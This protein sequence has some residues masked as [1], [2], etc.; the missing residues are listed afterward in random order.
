MPSG[1]RPVSE[2]SPTLNLTD[3]DRAIQELREAT[4]SGK[5]EDVARAAMTNIW[6]LYNAH[7][8][9]L[10]ASVEALPWLTLKQYPVLRIL[11]RMTPVLA[12]STAPFKPL[13]YPADARNMSQDELDIL[14]LVQMVAFRL[15]GD[16]AA[17]MIHARRLQERILNDRSSS[18]E[19]IDGPLWFYHQQIGT[20][21]LVAGESGP[22]LLEFATARELG[23]LSRQLDAQRMTLGRAALAHAVRGSFDDAE[24][25][26]E[27]ISLLPAPS[28]A[29]RVSTTMTERSACALVAVEKLMP[30]IDG[31]LAQLETYDSIEP[32]WPFALLARSRHLLAR[33]HAD[34]ALEGVRLARDAHPDQH[35]SFASDVISSISVEALWSVG[36]RS[37]A[38]RIG[39]SAGRSGLLTQLAIIR[40]DL[41]ESRLDDASQGLRVLAGDRSLGPGARAERSLLSAWLEYALTDTVGATT[42]LHVARLASRPGM[43]R[44]LSTMPIQ[45]IQHVQQHLPMLDADAFE[46]TV[47]GL[48]TVHQPRPPALT[49]SEIRVLNALPHH[50][51]T[52]EI[53]AVLFVSPNT[54][55]SQLRSLYRKLDCS[56]REEAIIAAAR[57]HLL[58]LDIAPQP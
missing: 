34:E 12:R 16:V 58:S 51:T 8:D 28:A 1:A 47:V 50:Q 20:T 39:E 40:M 41:L 9:E 25:A 26:L 55:K 19:E 44:L 7:F 30:D 5:P 4:S 11:H 53:A 37:T 35:G 56:T 2:R 23:I 22:A 49:S 6:P 36:D 38:R 31:L 24:R 43:R 14:T 33:H 54:I 17:A 3:P 10:T 42:A 29:H 48:A 18:H 57:F 15:S 21:L 46:T 27:E 13:V 45:L 32:T 52:A